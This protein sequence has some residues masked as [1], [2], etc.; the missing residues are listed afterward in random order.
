MATRQSY[1]NLKCICVQLKSVDICSTDTS[2]YINLEFI[3]ALFEASKEICK[4]FKIYKYRLVKVFYG[5]SGEPN[6]NFEKKTNLEWNI[7]PEIGTFYNDSD[8]LEEH[9]VEN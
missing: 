6:S 4:T 2:S 8:R 5:L 3:Q 9:S 1:Q 7:R